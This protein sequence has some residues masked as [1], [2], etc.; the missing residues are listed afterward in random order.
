MTATKII[1]FF[2]EGGVPKTGLSPVIDIWETDGT[3]VVNN[4]AMTEIAGGGYFYNFVAYDDTK[5]Y[6]IRADSV[7]LTGT[8]RYQGSSND[9]GQVT[10]PTNKILKIEANRLKIDSTAFT[11]TIYEDDKVTPAFVF[12]LKDASGV[13]TATDIF[14]RVPL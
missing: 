5:D 11:L 3:L 7:A 13:A 4:Q 6:F 10:D 8:E 14:E 12:D 2:T 9:L 1:S